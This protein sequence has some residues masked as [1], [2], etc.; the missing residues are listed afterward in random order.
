[1]NNLSFSDQIM[2]KRTLNVVVWRRAPH[3]FKKDFSQAE[4]FLMSESNIGI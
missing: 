2:P 1:M 3:H 4:D